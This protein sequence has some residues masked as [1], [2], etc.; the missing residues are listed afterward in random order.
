M[1]VG[2]LDDHVQIKG[3]GR[4]PLAGLAGRAAH[5]YG[6]LLLDQ[7]AIE[8]VFSMLVDKIL[9]YGACPI[10]GLAI[11]GIDFK[12]DERVAD[13]AAWRRQ[14]G[15]GALLFRKPLLRPAHFLQNRAYVPL[16]HRPVLYNDL[17]RCRIVALRAIAKRSFHRWL[18]DFTVRAAQQ[19]AYATIYCLMHSALSAPPTT[20]SSS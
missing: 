6:G 18:E 4:N 12:F 9:P 2:N 8:I 10:Y 3:I 17:E 20:R 7:A 14:G 1:R 16:D 15:K 11:T 5:H 19:F 13:L